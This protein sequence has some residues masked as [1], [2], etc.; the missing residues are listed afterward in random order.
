MT[1]LCKEIYTKF[2]I[3]NMITNKS[4]GATL[5]DLIVVPKELALFIEVELEDGFVI[6]KRE[7]TIEVNHKFGNDYL[8]KQIGEQRPDIICALDTT[9]LDSISLQ[10]IIN[11]I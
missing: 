11:D 4:F 9:Y 8:I 1:N 10:S 5:F 2:E 7:N 3:D 6:A